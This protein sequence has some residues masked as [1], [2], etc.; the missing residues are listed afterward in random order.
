M[1][2]A[3]SFNSNPGKAPW[4]TLAALLLV[5]LLGLAALYQGTMGFEVV[6]TE[7]DRRLAIRFNIV[8]RLC[9]ASGVELF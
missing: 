4:P 1:T 6:S 9:Q 8:S 2:A 7:D 3:E 5:C